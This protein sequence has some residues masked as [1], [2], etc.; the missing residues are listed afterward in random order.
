MQMEK[1][2][3]AIILRRE[4]DRW[5]TLL[6]QNRNGGHWAFPKGHVEEGETEKQTAIREVREETGL[7][8]EINTDFKMTTQYSPKKGVLKD[9]VYFLSVVNTEETHRQIEEIDAVKWFSLP[10]A[11]S[12]VTFRRD[13]EILEEAAEYAKLYLK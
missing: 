13:R 5:K 8:I 12:K 1:S 4:N 3:G 7:V 11:L 9:V 10:R 2:C 6:V